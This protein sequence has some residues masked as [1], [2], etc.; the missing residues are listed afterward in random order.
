LSGHLVS[1]I[2]CTQE[3]R[4]ENRRQKVF[5]IT[6][7]DGGFKFFSF[8]LDT[9]AVKRL[10]YGVDTCGNINQMKFSGCYY[11]NDPRR[12]IVTRLT[13][14]RGAEFY[15]YNLDTGEVGDAIGRHQPEKMD[16]GREPLQTLPEFVE[17]DKNG[18]AIF[19]SSLG[20][21]WIYVFSLNIENGQTEMIDHL[22]LADVGRTMGWKTIACPQV[23]YV[24]ELKFLMAA[25]EDETEP[26]FHRPGDKLNAVIFF[27]L[28]GTITEPEPEKP[29]VDVIDP[30]KIPENNDFLYDDISSTEGYAEAAGIE[31]NGKPVFMVCDTFGA[32]Y[33]FSVD[34]TTGK[35]RRI[36][37]TGD[38]LKTRAKDG[39]SLKEAHFAGCYT[40]DKKPVFYGIDDNGNGVLFSVDL[41][42]KAVAFLD[43]MSCPHGAKSITPT[44]MMPQ[45]G[46][47]GQTTP[48]F[49]IYEDTQ[50]LLWHY[51]FIGE[52]G[53][54]PMLPVH[55]KDGTGR[56]LFFS[57]EVLPQD[58]FG[59]ADQIIF[60]GVLES[61][62]AGIFSYDRRLEAVTR[63][64]KNTVSAKGYLHFFG[65][66]QDEAKTRP[67]FVSKGNMSGDS[68]YFVAFDFNTFEFHGLATVS[69][70]TLPKETYDNHEIFYLGYGENGKSVITIG[71]EVCFLDP[72]TGYVEAIPRFIGTFLHPP[73]DSAPRDMIGRCSWSPQEKL[74]MIAGT[75]NVAFWDISKAIVSAA[76]PSK[77]A[78]NILDPDKI[79][80]KPSEVIEG[81]FSISKA[82][83]TGTYL[84]GY[85]L[86]YAYGDSS[87]IY[88][89]DPVSGERNMLI[90]DDYA[91]IGYAG[92]SN[93]FEDKDKP[94]FYGIT[95]TG[96]VELF[97]VQ[98][99]KTEGWEKT[100]MSTATFPGKEVRA[101]TNI[102]GYFD[103]NPASPLFMITYKHHG[104]GLAYCDLSRGSITPLPM[105]FR[106][107]DP[108]HHNNTV[109]SFE[110]T[111]LH[112]INDTGQTMCA[113]TFKDGT[114]G[115][116][117][118]DVNMSS[119]T[120]IEHMKSGIFGNKFLRFT[121]AYCQDEAGND[122]PVKPIFVEMGLRKLRFLSYDI[123]NHFFNTLAERDGVSAHAITYIGKA[124]DGKQYFAFADSNKVE[125]VSF[126]KTSAGSGILWAHELPDDRD[127]DYW[128]VN[129]ITYV[130]ESKML[131][132]GTSATAEGASISDNPRKYNSI[133]MWDL[134]AAFGGRPQEIK[135]PKPLTRTGFASL[136]K[137]DDLS[138]LPSLVRTI[139][140]YLRDEKRVFLRQEK[141][142]P[143][144]PAWKELGQ[145]AEK[146]VPL[147][148]LNYL[149]DKYSVEI[150]AN[151]DMT[152]E[153][154]R[155]IVRR[156]KDIDITP[157]VQIIAS[158]MAGQNTT[159]QVWLRE[160][161]LQNPRDAVRQER[162]EGRMGPEEGAIIHR[163]FME[164]DTWVYSIRDP[165]GMSL[166]Q[167]VR[168][169]FPL[170]ES[171]KRYLVDTGNLG[172]GNYTLFA[173]FDTAFIR[174]STGDGII[175]EITLENDRKKGPI[176]TSWTVLEGRFKGS[177]VRRMKK[178]AHS[179]PNLESLFIQE[180]LENYG[181][182]VQSP[183]RR[184][185]R[186]ET[187]EH[188]DVLVTYNGEQFAEDISVTATVSLGDEYG[189]LS[190][191]RAKQKY[192][193]RVMQDEILVKAPDRK[194]YAFV[195]DFLVK[196]FERFGGCHIMI[197]RA[198][199]LNIPRSDYGETKVNAR[200]RF[201]KRLE[202]AV[203]HAMIKTILKDYE[204]NNAR[205]P[206]ITPDY[207]G[208][209]LAHDDPMA[210]TIAALMNA[211]RYDEID[212]AS[213]EPFLKQK[214]R[215]FELVTHVPF[216][217][218]IHP[219]PVTLHE[220]REAIFK[221]NRI[222]EAR[223]EMTGRK[224][225][226]L[227]AL[228]SGGLPSGEIAEDLITALGWLGAL[229]GGPA[230]GIV[231]NRVLEQSLRPDKNARK[232]PPE[233]QAAF[234]DFCNRLL[235][236]IG[237]N[238][239]RIG[240]FYEPT[241][242]I[243]RARYDMWWNLYRAEPWIRDMYDLLRDDKKLAEALN[244]AEKSTLWWVFRVL[245]HESQH[246]PLFEQPGDHTHHDDETIDEGFMARMGRALD[247][248]LF[249]LDIEALVKEDKGSPADCLDDIKLNPDL[250][251]L[252]R[253]KEQ[254]ITVNDVVRETHRLFKE[255]AIQREFEILRA[256]GILVPIKGKKYHYRFSDMMLGADE[257]HT[258]NMINMVN[259]IHFKIGKNTDDRPLHRGNIPK[260]PHDYRALVR[261]LVKM[262]VVHHKNLHLAPSIPGGK[263]LWHVIDSRLCADRQFAQ[264]AQKVNQWSR[265]SGTKERIRI[266]T[267]RETLEQVLTELKADRNALVDVALNS[268]EGIEPV[269]KV[270]GDEKVKMLVFEGETGDFSHL[271]GILAGLRA[272]HLQKEQIIPTLKEIYTAIGAIPRSGNK[273]DGEL[274]NLLDNPEQFARSFVYSLPP[275]TGLPINDLARLNRI[276]AEFMSAA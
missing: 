236:M 219:E 7:A 121:G 190:V 171:S 198:V 261:E 29:A 45:D 68:L 4:G 222:R 142:E 3:Y 204:D 238:D 144:D 26:K 232:L 33:F 125:L 76:A 138:G 105:S 246:H 231:G 259:D 100:T 225:R 252:A 194:E 274:F 55:I 137:D 80:R 107:I 166:W 205:L 31:Y 134:S 132:A 151:P 89:R 215:F 260:T 56:F 97:V 220:I 123:R 199:L 181:G 133:V 9:F 44:K 264:V 30:E 209:E 28:G 240:F 119:L 207:F 226:D 148:L 83:W 158:A 23:S 122:D 184:Q 206:G 208:D 217:S 269:K 273:T 250:M 168:Y 96:N 111:P 86:F 24:R 265:E 233:I 53:G 243:A 50:V 98:Y 101:L 249:G 17:Y 103:N 117:K 78:E 218:K 196:A 210:G 57:I 156:A 6:F 72:L 191:G 275:I 124:A 163:N 214:T 14:T 223:P 34:K 48:L 47:E 51:H 91:S 16:S 108:N 67:V 112:F 84:A 237:I 93:I 19:V 69:I 38:K 229:R 46:G 256:I 43:T 99:S 193:K 110:P 32:V 212:E 245:I 143:R 71:N 175:N 127:Y 102:G 179:D 128:E 154:F 12:P 136:D 155:D 268:E 79:P 115:M 21:H 239:P 200:L 82:R 120:E 8:D 114:S 25:T 65:V 88:T 116:F 11:K 126:S 180:A 266:V 39:V 64:S 173:D 85:P 61:G 203:L 186:E 92:I 41:Q 73:G 118:L 188:R 161:G 35:T 109:F 1:S 63:I 221:K 149:F 70:G 202:M 59:S 174:T 213:L 75:G 90:L 60:S 13:E 20:A 113:I 131:I 235:R 153:E 178:A 152:W 253:N 77:P 22:A 95:K 197:P 104:I 160:L 247:K 42:A 141:A 94:L 255:R 267:E 164:G 62:D 234:V 145:V 5:T 254:G 135:P 189:T 244:S 15:A 54:G 74:F 182:A 270:F 227:E 242:T 169:Y 157:Y 150:K 262:N 272:L 87:L 185:A 49:V 263:V 187:P 183:A 271:E 211:G 165:V 147:A 139:T 177:E 248:V 276:L 81:L 172:Q 66:Y 18:N 251:K 27:D 230:G 170:D 258:A 129:D 37:Y 195:P 162:D 36:L 106:A 140:G 201:M 10:R 228:F 146:P 58:P 241:G 2:D 52:S 167:L 224:T 40:P 216:T 257:D 130:P 159:E 192:R 176:I